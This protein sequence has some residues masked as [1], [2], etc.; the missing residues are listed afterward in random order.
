MPGAGRE[1]QKEESYN[2]YGDDARSAEIK[3]LEDHGSFTMVLSKD[4]PMGGVCIIG[5][6]AY[7]MR[8]KP[9]EAGHTKAD[10]YID[11]PGRLYARLARKTFDE[12][13]GKMILRQKRN[14]EV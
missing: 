13:S 3:A 14:C 8:H 1:I 5:R 9:S 12:L 2:F 4:V 10:A 11:D 7:T 6:F